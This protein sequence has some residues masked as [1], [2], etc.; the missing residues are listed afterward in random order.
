MVPIRRKIHM[1]D[2]DLRSL[3]LEDQNYEISNK[4]WK[5]SYLNSDRVTYGCQDLGDFEV[6]ADL[7]WSEKNEY[8][9]WGYH[10]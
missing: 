10:T 7:V 1:V 9:W 5:Y 3:L 2:P 4:G 8:A 6:P